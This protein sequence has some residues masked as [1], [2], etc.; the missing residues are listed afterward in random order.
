V[1][2]FK[3]FQFAIGIVLARILS[4]TEYGIVGLLMVIL[5]FFQVFVDS[6]FNMALIQKQDRS[7]IDLSTVLFF[8]IL[9][10]AL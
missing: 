8:N 3:S 10:S 9:I 5:A 1:C 2:L 4:P 6:G 7:Q